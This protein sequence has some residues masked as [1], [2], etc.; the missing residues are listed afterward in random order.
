MTAIHCTNYS[1]HSTFQLK[2][3]AYVILFL[4]IWPLDQLKKQKYRFLFKYTRINYYL[5]CEHRQSLTPIFLKLYAIWIIS[6]CS[7][8][9]LICRLSR[10]NSNFSMITCPDLII[11]SFV[12]WWDRRQYK[13]KYTYF[14]G[15]H[16]IIIHGK[17]EQQ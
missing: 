6:L 5:I 10:Q 14:I 15:T 16:S 11:Y 3:S 17:G 1:H 8:G 13:Y 2:F 7:E 12:L 9:Q 4:E